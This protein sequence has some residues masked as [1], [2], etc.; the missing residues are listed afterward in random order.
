MHVYTTD[1]PRDIQYL[2]MGN[3]MWPVRQ[4]YATSKYFF[5]VIDVSGEKEARRS[6]E[7]PELYFLYTRRAPR[8]A[9]YTDEEAEDCLL[10]S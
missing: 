2:K 6:Y 7:N 9:D 3:R 10:H 1:G 5:N 4:N 8:K